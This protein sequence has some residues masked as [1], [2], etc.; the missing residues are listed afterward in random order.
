M[1]YTLARFV[2]CSKNVIKFREC[3]RYAGHSKWA[4]IRH[5]KMAKDAERATALRTTIMKMKIAIAG[6]F[7]NCNNKKLD[8]HE[9]SIE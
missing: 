2:L 4:N 5:T 9:T 6:I 3:K 1:T 7:Y 8:K